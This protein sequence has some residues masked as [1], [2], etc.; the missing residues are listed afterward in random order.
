MKLIE[1]KTLG[2][3]AAFIEFSSIPQTATDLVILCSLRNAAASFSDIPVN[4]SFNGVT[5]GFSYRGVIGTGTSVFSNNGSTPILGISYG[6]GFTANTWNSIRVYIT[7]YSGAKDKILSADSITETMATN[8]ADVRLASNNFANTAAITSLRVV[9]Q[10]NSFA[11]G[12]T[13]SLY[14]ITK[15]SDGITTAS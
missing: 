11:V 6:G 8:Q 14:G 3:T 10:S 9:S 13:V 15:G 4:I 1:T 7:N 5:T 12:S 2:S